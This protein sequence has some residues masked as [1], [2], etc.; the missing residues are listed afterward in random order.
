LDPA[1][2]DKAKTV[3]K[4][5]VER[6]QLKI[7]VPIAAAPDLDRPA[8]VAVRFAAEIGSAQSAKGGSKKAAAAG[9][10]ASYDELDPQAKLELLTRLYAKDF[11]AEP[12]FPDAVTGIKSKPD[13]TA[14]KVDFLEKAIREHIQV[15]D[16]DLQTLGQDRAKALEQVLLADSQGGA[17]RVF[18]VGN[19][20]ATSKDGMV[21]LE[22]TLK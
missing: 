19:D 15:G 6:P 20:K 16:G 11:G 14:A 3:A 22:L 2:L 1:A 12:K 17:E 8:L 10:P 21:R 4:A 5:L 9:T 18:L 13:I 7:E